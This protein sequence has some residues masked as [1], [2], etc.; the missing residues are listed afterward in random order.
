[1]KKETTI[2]DGINAFA[3]FP[4]VLV[5]TQNNIITVALVHRFSYNPF[6]L[7]IGISHSRYSYQLI[8]AEEEFVVNI[9]TEEHL[10]QV[11]LCG[12]LS[13]RDSDKFAATGF[14]KMPGKIVKSSMIAECPVSIECKVTNKLELDER[15]WFVGDVVAVYVDDEY[16]VSKSLLCNRKAYQQIGREIGS[17]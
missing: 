1:M 15:T 17:R 3:G 16:D 5:T 14:A 12:R 11:R 9:P 10:E 4:V 8:D 6:M 7:G 2:R 13:G